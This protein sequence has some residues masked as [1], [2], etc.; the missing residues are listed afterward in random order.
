MKLPSTINFDEENSFDS[1]KYN[2]ILSLL[3]FVNAC[4]FQRQFKSALPK[5]FTSM[6]C[7]GFPS[8]RKFLPEN[9]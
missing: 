6:V 3:N 7:H 1:H 4:Y 5:N 8:L 9:I 2:L